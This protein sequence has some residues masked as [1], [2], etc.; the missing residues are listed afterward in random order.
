[1]P[2]AFPLPA[3]LTI[4]GAVFHR[5]A[6][7]SLDTRRLKSF[8]KIVDAGS[9]TRAADLLHIA[10]PALSQQIALLESQFKQKLLIRS[11]QGVKPTKAGQVL[12]RHALSILKQ[13]E[14][15]ENDIRNS[16][17]SLTG[18]VSVGLAPYSS[19]S[20]LS[21]AL[22]RQVRERYPDVQLQIQESF[23][24]AYSELV[25]NGRMDMAVL[26]GAGP[27]HGLKFTPLLAE[28]F[29]LVGPV[30]QVKEAPYTVSELVSL[31]LLL[32]SK[33][34]FVRKAVETAFSRARAVPRVVAEI[35]AIETLR[36]AVA[37]GMGLT[38][39]PWAVA[40]QLALP[41]VTTTQRIT[42]PSIQETIS[43]CVSDHMPLS[44]AAAAV[45]DIL[46]RLAAEFIA[47]GRWQDLR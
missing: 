14:Q 38:I 16:A 6:G 25:M 10:Q 8:V 1:M 13:L 22:L 24:G 46:H 23:T 29:H 32:P 26:H 27:I 30:E 40:R 45:N 15:A 35:E 9:V 28:D 17:E 2:R 41:G 31:P 5:L 47:E 33:M 34:N 4:A 12:Y 21:L 3:P 7:S 18:T 43:V 11:Q 44:E 20:S 36:N 19:A 37:Q 42:N 39:M